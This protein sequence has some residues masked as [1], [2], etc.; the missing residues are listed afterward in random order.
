MT[1][2][3]VSASPLAALRSKTKSTSQSQCVLLKKNPLVA[4]ATNLQPVVRVRSGVPAVI[5]R[6][7]DRVSFVNGMGTNAF[8][9]SIKEPVQ[10]VLTSN[11]GRCV[12]LVT[13]LQYD[14]FVL[15]LSSL[16]EGKLYEYLDRYVF[17]A[18]DVELQKYAIPNAVDVMGTRPE[19]IHPPGD[20]QALPNTFGTTIVDRELLREGGSEALEAQSDWITSLGTVAQDSEQWEA[21]RIQR[22][23]P[24]LGTDITTE[25]NPLESGLW[26]WVSFEKGCYIG[27]GTIARLHIND[28]VRRVLLL[29][30][31]E[32]VVEA[33]DE[34]EG[35][36]EDRRAAGKL[37]SVS[38][39]DGRCRALGFVR[40]KSG[41]AEIGS[42]VVVNGVK[43]VVLDAPFLKHG[44]EDRSLLTL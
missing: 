40:R 18:D 14:D 6:G 22:G 41:L 35:G 32:G 29:M 38:T 27:Q 36:V 20:L 31:F 7:E 4:S 43:G 26:H 2:L 1:L 44:Y 33:G 16:P 39:V 3:F 10:T 21:A 5:V 11:I 12:D 13:A 9:A 17:P 34:I 15:L 23:I 19:G 8:S 24:L 28:G 25:Y 37:T 42:T 30:E